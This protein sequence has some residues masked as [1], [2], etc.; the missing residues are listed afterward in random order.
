MCHLTCKRDFADV[1]KLRIFEMGR[2]SWII[3]VGLIEL[4]KSFFRFR[5]IDSEGDV[6]MEMGVMEERE[7]EG[8]G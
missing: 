8:E 7:R 1:N 5:K 3:Q 2:L 6:I 4:Q